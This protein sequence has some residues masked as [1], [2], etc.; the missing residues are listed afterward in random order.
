MIFQGFCLEDWERLRWMFDNNVG[1]I[2]LGYTALG[3]RVYRS[4]LGFRV[5]LLM[6][7]FLLAGFIMP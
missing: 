1:T 6:T 4:C 7:I 5:R 3:L 2:C